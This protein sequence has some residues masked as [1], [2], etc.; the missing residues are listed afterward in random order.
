M[1]VYLG[2]SHS[3]L[4]KCLFMDNP[5]ILYPS[6]YIILSSTQMAADNHNRIGIDFK[7]ANNAALIA[8]FVPVAGFHFRDVDLWDSIGDFCV[9]END[10]ENAD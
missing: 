9:N 6:L 2:F 8:N 5:Q 4:L 1:G 3:N 10:E 7:P